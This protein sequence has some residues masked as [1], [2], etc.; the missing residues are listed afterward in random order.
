[1]EGEAKEKGR[2]TTISGSGCGLC[3]AVMAIGTFESLYWCFPLSWAGT[4]VM[5]YF[6]YRYVFG[7][8]KKKADLEIVEA[9]A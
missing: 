3:S 5:H 1:M 8:E 2:I 7:K 6:M 9:Q 4:F